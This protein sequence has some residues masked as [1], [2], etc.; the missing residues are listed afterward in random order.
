MPDLIQAGLWRWLTRTGME[1]FELHRG[2]NEWMLRGTILV[3]AEGLPTEARYEVVCDDS[4]RTRRADIS[5]RD[6]SGERSLKVAVEDGS[7]FAN[8]RSIET[9][10]GCID[11]DLEWSP[12][13]NT[14]PIRRLPLAV[15]ERS[16]PIVAAWVR[17]PNLELQPLSQEYQRIAGNRYRYVSNHGAFV[18]E[19]AVDEEG[20][21]TEYEGLW[22]RESAK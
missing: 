13:T 14:L 22:R 16:G 20:L 18:A 9:V 8:G 4:W 2:R 6:Q 21:V 19:L 5:L 11:I 12:S 17:F 1:R 15:G 3:M 7:W 10:K